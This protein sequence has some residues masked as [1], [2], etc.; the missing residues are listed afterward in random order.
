M[1][2]FRKSPINQDGFRAFEARE[3]GKSR[4]ADHTG[5]MDPA[6]ESAVSALAEGQVVGVPTDTV[7]GLAA[8]AYRSDAVA[9][10]FALK[11][12][13]AGKAIPILVSRIDQADAIAEVGAEA[14]RLAAA[15]WPGPL[16]LVVPRRRGLPEWIG[17]SGT[18][19]VGLRVPD[20][21]P[22]LEVADISGPLATT[23]AN[24]SGGDPV[25]DDAAAEEIFG[26]AVAYYLPGSCPGGIGSTVVDVTGEEPELLREGLLPWP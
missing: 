9:R 6:V 8:D 17:D 23:S 20:H 14:R 11:Q 26:D 5:H 15:H 16:T 22:L 2:V 21:G 7:Y 13:P 18:E 19:T 10:L 4:F 24:R 12:R 1:Q 25:L 3:G